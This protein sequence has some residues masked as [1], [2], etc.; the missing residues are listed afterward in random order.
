M[1]QR[2]EL[3]S[4]LQLSCCGTQGHLPVTK[5]HIFLGSVILGT[6]KGVS[7][8]EARVDKQCSHAQSRKVRHKDK[9][10]PRWRQ[11]LIQIWASPAFKTCLNIGLTP[12]FKT[13]LTSHQPGGSRGNLIGH[14]PC[15]GPALALGR[16]TRFCEKHSPARDNCDS[17]TQGSLETAGRPELADP[18]HLHSEGP[19]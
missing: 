17:E 9:L 10:S 12:A 14:I 18:S 4:S 3:R 5:C 13:Q 19:V 16:V 7:S 11:N 15:C 1:E 2:L 8:E 6:C